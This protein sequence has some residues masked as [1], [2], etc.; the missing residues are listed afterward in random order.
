MQQQLV[1]G[2]DSARQTLGLEEE[3]R[4]HLRGGCS[5]IWFPGGIHIGD[6]VFFGDSTMS[7]K[8]IHDMVTVLVSLDQ[9]KL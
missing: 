6:K 1:A 4:W 3:L 2:L 5:C 7:K 9:Y 8:N